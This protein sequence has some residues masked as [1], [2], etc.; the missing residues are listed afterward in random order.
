MKA[1]YVY[2]LF[3]FGVLSFQALSCYAQQ[4]KDYYFYTPEE[5]QTLKKSATTRW[6]KKIVAKLQDEIDNRLQHSMVVP[7][8]E[9]GH[10]HHYF[11]PIHNTQFVFDWESPD[12]HYCQACGKKWENVD[13]YNWAWINVVHNEN[14][15]FL[16]ANMYMYL[17]TGKKIYAEHI[18]RLLSDYAAKY[19]GYIEHD[20]E[21]KATTAYSGRMFAQSLDEAVWA[22]DAARAYL[23]ASEVMTADEKQQIREGYLKI[24][25]NMLLNRSDKGNWQIWHN[26][27]IASLGVALKNDSII[28]LALKKPSLGYEDMLE[29]NVYDDGWWNEGSIVYHFY[30]LRSL[31][32]TA[33]AVRCRRINLYG[34]KLYNMFS[35]PVNMLYPDLTFPSQNDGWY[36]TSLVS[37]ASLYEIVSLR[38]PDPLFKNLLALCY[39]KTERNSPEALFNGETLP[40]D[41]RLLDL[42][43]YL[44]PNLGVGILR[45]KNNMLVVKYGPSGGLHGHPDKLT[46]TLHNGESEV[47]PDLGT[48]AYGVPDC[49]TWYR[50]SISHSTVTIDGKDQ[51]PST[52]QLIYFHPSSSGGKIKVCVDSAYKN[53]KMLRSVSLVGNKLEDKYECISDTEHT[54]D[55]VL[56]LKEPIEFGGIEDTSI[57]K[58]Y[59][60]ISHVKQKKLQGSLQFALSNATVSIQ[61]NSNKEVY[62]ISGVAPGIPPSGTQEGKNVYP[63]IIRVKDKKM[64][65][66]TQCKLKNKLI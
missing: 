2:I 21:R 28:H 39:R 33:E 6:G 15:K 4:D 17:I 37:Q 19:P 23:V 58:N 5:I 29:K 38:Y 51:L 52:G 14:L 49:Y 36:G 62:V 22:I 55:Y 20:R 26:G 46:L 45:S 25:A 44:F 27:A 66:V 50:K 13:R 56:I 40:E 43:S 32:L 11:C 34:K 60:R 1:Q 12:A 65:I 16:K 42:K 64:D 8:V 54:Y 31:L 24:C 57:L 53:V 7:S 10:G 9:G 47:F 18:I 30:P 3:L 41:V 48:P 59:E 61:V 35:A 63:L